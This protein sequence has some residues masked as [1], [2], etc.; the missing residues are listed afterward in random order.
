MTYISVSGARRWPN[1]V[2]GA[3][4]CVGVAA[5]GSDPGA[6]GGGGGGSG[7]TP[8]P[9]GCLVQNFQNQPDLLFFPLIEDRVGPPG[10]L[11]EFSI[12]VDGDTRL[13][14]ATLMDAWRLD[15]TPPAQGKSE[16]VMVP[17]TGNK[18]IDLA[19]QIN[20]T[21]RYYVELELCADDCD[22]LRVLYTLNREN[23]GE[24]SDPINDPY[25]RIVYLGEDEVGTSF[26]CDHPDS[27]A[28][29]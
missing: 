20:T 27:I 24:G 25:E 29:Q 18:T 14:K 6:T 12:F 8:G 17:T 22:E 11:V 16:T 13:V 9:M 23:A 19:I 1:L 7:G 3:L 10:G 2:L 5:C 4:L 15:P 28:I 26:T 21:G